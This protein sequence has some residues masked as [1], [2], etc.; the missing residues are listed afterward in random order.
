M[1]ELI[2]N[3]IS[4]VEF[5]SDAIKSLGQYCVDVECSYGGED[6]YYFRNCLKFE[7]DDFD[8]AVRATKDYIQGNNLIPSQPGFDNITVHYGPFWGL[9]SK[10]LPC[11]DIQKE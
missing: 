6:G 10:P 9:G 3:S 11:D 1:K 8:W 2:I 5:R 4:D 7:N